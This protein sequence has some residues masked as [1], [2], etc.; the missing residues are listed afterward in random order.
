MVEKSQRLEDAKS[1][2]LLKKAW[3]AVDREEAERLLFTA[4]LGSYLFR[5]DH[6]ASCLEEILVRAKK[7]RMNCYTLTY[8]GT[9]QQVREKTVVH[10]NDHWLFY[11]DDPSLMGRSFTSLEILLRS[12]GS[13]LTKPLAL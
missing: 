6:F 4:P 13:A 10:W 2:Q 9:D 7:G 1:E 8:L 3:H 11:D 12:L 5:K